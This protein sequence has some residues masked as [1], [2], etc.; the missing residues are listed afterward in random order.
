VV[1]RATILAVGMLPPPIG[2]QA[3]MFKRAVE[4]LP[5][6][7]DLKVIDIQFQKNLGESGLFSVRKVLH[8]FTLLFGKIIPSVFAKKFDIL[9][10]C[11]SG[12]STLGLI[13]DLIFLGLLRSRARWTVYHFHGAGGVAFLMQSNALLRAWA[14]LVLFEPD[15][16]LRPPGATSDDA[17]LCKAKR[18]I[19]VNNAIEDPI[20]MVSEN[21]RQWPDGKLSFAFVGLVTEEKGVFDLVEIARL[22]RDGGRRFVMSIVGEGS[23]KETA[24]LRE[25]IRRYDLAEFVRLPGVLVGQQKFKLLQE[26]T[27]YLFPTYFRAETHPTAIMEALALGVP[28]VAS[29][30]RAI[31][32]IIDHAVNGYIV[33]PRNPPAFYRAIETIL[34]EGQIDRMRAA[35]RRIFLERF[36][37]DRHIEALRLAFDSL[38]ATGGNQRDATHG[39]SAP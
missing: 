22:L 23:P 11:L 15:L 12:P 3:L 5:K 32:T 18:E 19:V 35:A 30:W 26:T 7:Y 28:V 24:R 13:K 17:A 36:T 1:K 10:Y 2:G 29:D 33:P 4:A 16:V 6:H 9:Y 20:A 25:L 21:G 38:N 31:N 27:I 34:T 14:R 8:F 39:T 37:L